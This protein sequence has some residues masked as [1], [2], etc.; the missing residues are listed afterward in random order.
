MI[1]VIGRGF[2]RASFRFLFLFW[3]LAVLTRL[4]LVLVSWRHVVDAPLQL[5]I[6]LLISLPFDL[7]VG[8]TLTSVW[9]GALAVI[10][11]HWFSVGKG[12]AL[13]A[14][15][16]GIF[17]YAL[18]FLA[19]SEFVFW[20]E[21]QARLN[22]IAIDYLTYTHE[23]VQNI[24]QSYPM[25]WL[26]AGLS[27]IAFLLISPFW[28][29]FLNDLAA[30]STR[31]SRWSVFALWILMAMILMT[32][33]RNR[34]TERFQNPYY[35]ELARNGLFSM[36]AAWWDQGIRYD[37]FFLMIDRQEAYQ[38]MKKDL[39][40]VNSHFLSSEPDNL[41]RRV[42]NGGEEKR[43]NVIQITVESLSASYLGVFGNK[44]NLT[45]YLDRIS[46]ESLFFTN[47][48]ATGSRT[49]RGMESLSLSIPPTPGQSILRR[50]DNQ[51][52]FSLGAL[53]KAR[54]YDNAFI[55]GGRGYFDNMNA[56]FSG[57][58]FRIHDQSSATP[59][60]IT[61]ENAWGAC[62]EDVF[63]WVLREGDDAYARKTP[64]F[65]FVMT[66]SNHRPF[67]FPEGK[68]DIPQKTHESGVK[69]TDYAIG[70]FLEKAKS[71]PW[72]K[73]TI[74]VIIAD[75][76]ARSSGKTSIPLQEYHIPLLIW[77]PGL[78]PPQ[79]IEKR[80]SQMDVAP[81]I[82]GLLN[83]SYDT[84]F[85]GK[86]IL[87][88]TPEEERAF[89]ATYQKLGYYRGDQIA[90]LEPV[91]RAS[92]YKVVGPEM[93]FVPIQEKTPRLNE[94]IS[95]YQASSDLIARGLYRPKK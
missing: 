2:L 15:A 52:L 86:D 23:V 50:E 26:L 56:F 46:Q 12:K 58:G 94:A 81:T 36:G 47:L 28:K 90:I 69:Y 6:S 74:F 7:A 22:F 70:Q 79:K 77:Q 82:A 1:Q 30:D 14:F 34:M 65:H 59:D 53:F 45:P 78:I 35:Q 42:Q 83:W 38:F 67:T 93:S 39:L 48:Y 62:D 9:I 76:C 41:W 11:P 60:S 44:E 66:T 57:N 75:H 18:L 73:E 54:G 24:W 27:V 95:Y 64:F 40:T 92:E 43:L 80:C 19:A 68:I 87:K 51:N 10:P 71:K 20:E 37:Q 29:S 91:R 17:G 49:V 32:G 25:G 3:T 72:F 84:L 8:F 33:L 21:F 61:F 88:M 4:G 85:F 89:S 13:L 31:S 5:L 55:Y 16:L 63:N